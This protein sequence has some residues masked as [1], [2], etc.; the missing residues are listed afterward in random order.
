MLKSVTRL[1][2]DRI[3]AGYTLVLIVALCFMSL[4]G[5]FD[6][7]DFFFLDRA[8]NLR[9]HQ[10]PHPSVAVIAVSQEDF[11]QGAPRWPWPR[12]LMARLVDELAEERPAVIALD[13]QYGRKT[14]SETLLTRDTFNEIQPYVYQAL[15]GV[16]L[17]IQRPE[18]VRVIGPGNVAFDR[19]V[20]GAV[21][22]DAQD[23]EL[24][25]A[26]GRA[27]DMGIPVILAA[28]TISRSGVRGLSRPY[29]ALLESADGYLGL[30]GVRT[31]DDGV[32][33]RYIPYGQDEDGAFVYGLALEAVAT[34]LKTPLPSRPTAG[35]DVPIGNNIV[36]N[37]DNDGSFLVNFPGPPGTHF[38]VNAGEILDGRGDFVGTLQ[39]K[40]LF[41]G[42]SDPSVEDLFPTPFSGSERMAGVEFHASVASAILNNALISTT[43]RYQ[44]LM[45][46][47]LLVLVAVV[48]GRFTR[49]VLGMLAVV[50]TAVALLSAWSSAFSQ[51]DHVLPVAGPLAALVAAYAVAIADRLRV[52]RLS[53]LQARAMLS[54]YLPNGIVNQMLKESEAARLDARRA[55]VTILF[56][57]IRGFTAIS[58][59]LPPEEVVRLL[60]EY[61]SAMTE[62]IFDHGGTIDKF[63]GDA[64]LAFFGAPQRHDDDPKRAVRTA[65][66]MRNQLQNLQTRWTETTKVALE[67]GIGINT[68]SVMVGNIGSDR[69]MDYTVIGDAVN[70]AA[71]LQEMTKEYDSSILISG[72]VVSKLDGGFSTR[73][74]GEKSVRGRGR[75]VDLYEVSEVQTIPQTHAS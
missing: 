64:I 11:E 3:Y 6:R 68:G 28:Q 55:E 24:A 22:A 13:I 47:V 37:V 26:V 32:L 31:D 50:V 58:E 23:Q 70:L 9:G 72:E 18:G 59:R 29:D 51:A 52:E 67:I 48:I 20:Q 60:N 62:I 74:L 17:E 33:R 12:S 56:A 21:S 61:L 73:S 75:P 53:M 42:V 46:M 30:V 39:G 57:D 66:A 54:R 49:P 69:R 10:D 1:A 8:F 43:P 35:G 19:I 2:I 36:V 7:F 14:S 45:I 41:I 25:D 44:V 63:E 4:F 27:V 15:A 71:R 65:L 40:I 5:L 38:T 16:A 34:Y